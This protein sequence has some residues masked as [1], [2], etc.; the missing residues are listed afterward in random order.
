MVSSSL[1]SSSLDCWS[2]LF[3]SRKDRACWFSWEAHR[4]ISGDASLVDLTLS[5]VGELVGA[6]FRFLFAADIDLVVTVGRGRVGA[7]SGSLLATDTVSSS[8]LAV[9][10]W[11]LRLEDAVDRRNCSLPALLNQSCKDIDLLLTDSS[12]KSFKIRSDDWQSCCCWSV[13]PS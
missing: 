12:R 13:I 10:R 3:V 11:F 4:G 2:F 8:V 7:L 5:S 1:H 6:V 9:V